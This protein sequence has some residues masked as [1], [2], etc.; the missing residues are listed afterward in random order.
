LSRSGRKRASARKRVGEFRTS[1][2][3]GASGKRPEKERMCYK[4]WYMFS[5]ANI[6]QR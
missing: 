6:G 2:V 5:D 3:K 4:S 1:R